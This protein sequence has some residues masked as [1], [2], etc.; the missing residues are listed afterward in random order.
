MSSPPPSPPSGS[1][2]PE[3]GIGSVFLT[4]VSALLFLYLGF[5]LG[6]VG[7]S[8]DRVYDGSVT[9]FVWGARLI[10]IGLL[11][12]AGMIL[13]RVPGVALLGLVLAVLATLLCVVVGVIWLLHSDHQGLLLVLFGLFNFAA[14]R[15]AWLAVRPLRPA[16]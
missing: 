2:A 13:L 16:S 4:L 8:G 3:R 12:E 5:G 7:A 9:A 14:A 1:R 6:L 15:D 10:G 11:A